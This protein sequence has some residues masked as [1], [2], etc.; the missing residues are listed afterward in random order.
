MEDAEGTKH[1][2]SKMLS[3]PNVLGRLWGERDLPALMRVWAAVLP[4]H[5]TVPEVSPAVLPSVTAQDTVKDVSGGTE[6]QGPDEIVNWV[7]TFVQHFHMATPQLPSPCHPQLF[8]SIHSQ[9][10]FFYS[11]SFSTEHFPIIHEEGKGK[12]GLM[13]AQAETLQG[14]IIIYL[15]I[16]VW[17]ASS[18]LS[19]LQ[20]SFCV[21][22]T[23]TDKLVSVK[24]WIEEPK[25]F[26]FK[27]Q[28]NIAST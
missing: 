5:L 19:T 22:F 21:R 25:P 17:I 7:C 9:L 16:W 3:S 18:E 24:R 4:G 11:W 2:L 1:S 27:F 15:F 20:S 12:S 6:G 26:S 10:A 8:H 28:E 13:F 23:L 14:K